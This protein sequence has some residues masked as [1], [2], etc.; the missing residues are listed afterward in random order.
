MFH[1]AGA[2]GEMFHVCGIAC[3]CHV[4]VWLYLHLDMYWM[5]HGDRVFWLCLHLDMYWMCHG[6]RVF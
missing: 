4:D 3:V 2:C 1:G 5:C 6:D